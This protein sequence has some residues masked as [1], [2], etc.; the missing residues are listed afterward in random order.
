M[1]MVRRNF[2]EKLCFKEWL[3]ERVFVFALLQFRN[4]C[5]NESSSNKREKWCKVKLLIVII[6][7]LWF[8]I[9]MEFSYGTIIF[10]LWEFGFP[11][12]NVWESTDM[13]T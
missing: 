9:L 5:R 8:Y 4:I 1:E 13:V 7:K 3:R 10:I 2:K 12:R 11:R 6:L